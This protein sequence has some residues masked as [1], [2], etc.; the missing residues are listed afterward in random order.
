MRAM[1]DAQTTHTARIAIFR[2]GTH[3]AMSGA[4]RAYTGAELAACA[5]AYDPAVF[6]APVVVGH[7]E[8]NAPAY[9]W[10]KALVLE[11]DILYAE[12][13]D[14]DAAFT[15]AVKAGRYKKVSAAFYLP[16]A[17]TNPV[18]GVLYLRHVGFLGGQAPAVKGLPAVSFAAGDYEEMTVYGCASIDQFGQDARFS[19]EPPTMS[20]QDKAA[21]A[22]AIAERDALAQENARLK[23]EADAL[24]A[25]S[26]RRERQVR[27][28]GNVA[29]CESLIAA[30]RVPAGI[31]AVLTAALDRL[32]EGEGETL[33]RFGEGEAA[34]P[35]VAA[36]REALS[37]LPPM[38][39]F[40]ERAAGAGKTS[41]TRAEFEALD[42]AARHAAIQAGVRI[43]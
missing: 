15:K 13:G 43:A 14:L 19:E 26:A 24:R 3:T 32:G 27:H 17:P 33:A 35:L 5:A 21:F 37:G 22:A 9:G 41:L 11:G 30:G 12:V 18:P 25:A 36:F 4:S 8:T 34:R 1:P 10:V 16:E 39:D 6:A 20:D 29:F 31:Q 38:A 40:S 7:P 2:A 28:D 23:A 42:P